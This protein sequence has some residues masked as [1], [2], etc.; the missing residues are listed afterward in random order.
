MMIYGKVFGGAALLEVTFK[1]IGFYSH[2]NLDIIEP[3]NSSSLQLESR[4]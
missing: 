2:C 1:Q 3:F 4:I